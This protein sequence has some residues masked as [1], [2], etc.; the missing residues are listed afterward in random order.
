MSRHAIC[1]LE[2]IFLYKV[3]L[4]VKDAQVEPGPPEP[5]WIAQL[6]I[7]GRIGGKRNPMF[8]LVAHQ[9]SNRVISDGGDMGVLLAMVSSVRWIKLNG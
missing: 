1:L 7:S 2:K 9:I 4:V 5:W 6:G 3:N 8:R